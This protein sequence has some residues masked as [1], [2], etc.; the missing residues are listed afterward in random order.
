[1]I[2]RILELIVPE[3]GSL[4]AQAIVLGTIEI[5]QLGSQCH[6]DFDMPILCRPTNGLTNM[7]FNAKVQQSSSYFPCY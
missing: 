6:L 1:V 5:F 4:G 3:S 7:T 2:G